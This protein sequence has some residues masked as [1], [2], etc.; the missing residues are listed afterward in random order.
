MAE[1]RDISEKDKPFILALI[2][3]AITIMNILIA[4]I[5]AYLHNEDLTTQGMETL[6][7]TFPLTMAAW[8]YYLG[9]NSQ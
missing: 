3:S 6:K 9:K 7:F 8:T 4:A 2:A 1:N 5:G